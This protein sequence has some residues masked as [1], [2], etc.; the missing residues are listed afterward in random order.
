MR[1]LM[2]NLRNNLISLIFLFITIL[3]TIFILTQ[4]S[5]E[6][7][8]PSLGVFLLKLLPFVSATLSIAYLNFDE[9]LRRTLSLLSV[10]AAFLGFFCYFVPKLF[11]Y[12]NE[13][14][15]M[16]QTMLLTVPYIILALAFS[17]R[18]G[19]GSTGTTLRL[20]F[21]MLLLM[22]SGIEDLA[23]LLLSSRYDPNWAGMPQVWEWASHMTVRVGRPLTLYEAYA[24]IAVHLILA[25]LVMFYPFR[26]GSFER[27]FPLFNNRLDREN[28]A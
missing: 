23:F 24:F 5:M 12:S 14:E 4:V 25:A 10:P 9:S 7:E 27:D 8:I 19:G 11:F 20:S 26:R 18:M 6:K 13:F 1:F 15:V 22:I 28:A 3:L 16:Y 17:Y 2:T 21:A